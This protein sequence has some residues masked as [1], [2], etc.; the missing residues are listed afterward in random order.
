MGHGLLIAVASLVWLLCSRAQSQKLWLMALAALWH[1]ESSQTR[2]RTRVPCIAMKILNHWTTREA[3]LQ[4]ACLEIP[5]DRGA[6]QA[7]VHGVAKS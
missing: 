6:W 5:M 7:I 1:V 3:P 2:N 4:Y